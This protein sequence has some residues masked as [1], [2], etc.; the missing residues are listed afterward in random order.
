[1]ELELRIIKF[2]RLIAMMFKVLRQ[3]SPNGGA[4]LTSPAPRSKYRFTHFLNTG[5]HSKTCSIDRKS[6]GAFV[7]KNSRPK[8]HYRKKVRA[9]FRKKVPSD[10][11]SYVK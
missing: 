11:I 7:K 8:S 6:N 10:L 3:R 2:T 5:I 9:F 1:M 4:N